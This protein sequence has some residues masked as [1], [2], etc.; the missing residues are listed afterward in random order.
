MPSCHGVQLDRRREASVLGYLDPKCRL[1]SP[2]SWA[3]FPDSVGDHLCL[4]REGI[5][6]RGSHALVILAHV[7]S[8]SLDL[9]GLLLIH[10]GDFIA[11][12]A[13]RVQ[14]FI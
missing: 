12:V 4:Q 14:D 3:R 8:L 9:L 5:R 6:R 2:A 13:K 10:P 7:L 11:G 1:R